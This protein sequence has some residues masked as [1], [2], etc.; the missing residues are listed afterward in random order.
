MNGV[1][2]AMPQAPSASVTAS[3]GVRRALLELGVTGGA[4]LLLWPLCVTLQRVLGLERAELAVGFMM[5]HA[6]HA[7]ND[8]HFAVT[9]LLFYRDVRARL[10]SPELA[11]AQRLRYL[12]AGFVLPLGLVAWAASALVSRSA[13]SLGA[14]TQLMYVLV[15]FHYVKQGFGVV[16]LLSARRGVQFAATERRALLAHCYAAWA[17]GW[18]SPFDPGSTVAE[19]G[20][21]YDTLAHPTWL[22]PVTR[23]AFFASAAWL[24]L[25][26]FNKWRRERRLPLPP[27]LGFLCTLWFWTTY[28]G[29]DPLLI[30]VIPALHSVQ[31][32]YFVWLLKHGEASAHEG[33]PEFGRPARVV[34]GALAA[35]ALLLGLVLFH[36]LP[37]GLD[38]ALVDARAA[39]ATDLGPTPY[40]AAIF[41]FLN[42]HHYF[43]DFVIWRRDNP[44]A[45][46]LRTAP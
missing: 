30:Y 39:A 2:V 17:Y 18:A 42:L 35:G 11:R 4:T 13:P 3:G 14:M 28:S 19:K 31:Y 20:V 24:A 1:V 6:A 41:T 9:Y 25:T 43:M 12:M 37:Q 16:T 44:Q 40:F 29:L 8:P 38:A 26:L 23:A 22:E 27:L 5:F 10:T 34:V 36:W 7:I 32:L 21:V 15:G 46:Y 45:R 33:P